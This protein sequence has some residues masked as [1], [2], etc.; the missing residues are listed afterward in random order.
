MPLTPKELEAARLIEAVYAQARGRKVTKSIHIWI[1]PQPNSTGRAVLNSLLS[2]ALQ[3]DARPDTFTVRGQRELYDKAVATLMPKLAASSRGWALA[4]LNKQELRIGQLLNATQMFTEQIHKDALWATTHLPKELPVTTAEEHRKITDSQKGGG[5][6]V[7]VRL[8]RFSYWQAVRQTGNTH[9]LALM[10]HPRGV[11]IVD[12]FAEGAQ[13]GKEYAEETIEACRV[14]IRDLTGDLQDDAGLIWRL[15]AAIGPGVWALAGG[16][17]LTA[18]A[19]AWGAT[20]RSPLERALDIAGN[21]TLLL[22][23]A[24]PVGMAIGDILDVVLA[25]TGTATS[26]LADLEQDR[27]ALAGAFGGDADK[28]SQGSRGFGTL[29]QGAIAI[30]AA[31]AVPGA[32]KQLVGRSAGAAARIEAIATESFERTERKDVRAVAGEISDADR[33]L[34]GG[35]RAGASSQS[36]PVLLLPSRSQ[37]PSRRS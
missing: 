15:P 24:G 1:R 36:E 14:A 34:A 6:T 18:F 37:R 9:L 7:E 22:Q 10:A 26:Y 12:R 11:T 17:S 13:E 29:L 23:L 32:V 19:L 2:L 3:G 28:L 30:L 4:N 27:A 35:A 25:A 33:G 20:E 21:A 16:P 31:V 8:R 5:G